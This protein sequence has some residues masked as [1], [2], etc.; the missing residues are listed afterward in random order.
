MIALNLIAPVKKQELRLRQFYIV[1]KNLTILFLLF[2]TVA[3]MILLIAK[4]ILQNHFNRVV[5]DTTLTTKFGQI[6]NAEIGEFNQQLELIDEIQKNYITWTDFIAKLSPLVP[7][8][9]NLSQIN[10]AKKN[11]QIIITGFAQ[12]RDDLLKFK[13]ELENFDLLSNVDV[14]LES[15][16][17]KENINFEIRTNINFE[18]I[19]SL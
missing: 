1:I 13:G 9:V 19:E 3:A 12:N 2:A 5:A 17:Q 11:N 18:K 14:P 8:N 4:F 7:N 10:L 15:L 16:F 6:F